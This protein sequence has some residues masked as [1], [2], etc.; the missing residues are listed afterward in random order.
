[1]ATAIPIIGKRRSV[2][3]KTRSLSVNATEALCIKPLK[4]FLFH[5]KGSF[6][7]VFNRPRRQRSHRKMQRQCASQH[8]KRGRTTFERRD[9]S[10]KIGEYLRAVRSAGGEDDTVGSWGDVVAV[11]RS[12]DGP[13][14]DEW[15][16]KKHGRDC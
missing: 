13:S 8:F 3:L 5:L 4:H 14:W 10:V 12:V 16:L 2:L 11:A 1:M 15:K 7:I 9:V 6:E